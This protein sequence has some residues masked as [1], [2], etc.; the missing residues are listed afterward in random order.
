VKAEGGAIAGSRPLLRWKHASR[1]IEPARAVRA[2]AEEAGLMGHSASLCS[3]VRCRDAARWPNVYMAVNLSPLQVR[4]RN[5]RS[6]TEVG[7]NED[8]AVPRVLE[9]TEGV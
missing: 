9:I 2:V 6:V 1:G 7:G 3:G 5:R 4:D 8:F